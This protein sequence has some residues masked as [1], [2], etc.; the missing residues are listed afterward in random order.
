M[1]LIADGGSTKVDWVVLDDKKLEV[2]RI[3]SEGLNPA[4][5]DLKELE[6]R[7]KGLSELMKFKEI[8]RRVR[9]YGAGCGTEK[10]VLLLRS[11]FLSFFKNAEVFVAEDMLGA[12]HAASGNNESIVCILGTGSNSCYYDGN[13]MFS[14]APSLGYII[15]DEASGNY[16]GKILLRD[17]FYKEMPE[18]LRDLFREHFNLEV[19]FIKENLYAN[20]SPNMYLANFS[21]FMFDHKEENYI[22]EI[23]KEG[24]DVFLKKRVLSY[25]KNR[26]TPLYF[27]GSIAHYFRDMLEECAFNNNLKI[28]D[29]IQRPL[30]NLIKY[31]QRFN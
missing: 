3:T 8:I 18:S 13:V 29:V 2:I 1:L 24:F 19:D 21:K 23:I 20:S 16:F 31:H 26:N 11:V 15:M 10:S 5:L 14:N 12:V 4:I 22:R 25:N 17:Y 9:F 28:K 6:V 30:D 27:I 7:L